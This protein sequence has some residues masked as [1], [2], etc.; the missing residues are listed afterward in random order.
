MTPPPADTCRM[1]AHPVLLSGVA[2]STQVVPD[3]ARSEA[4]GT[5]SAATFD[6]RVPWDC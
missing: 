4:L 5:A 1:S 6:G 2:S 3:P